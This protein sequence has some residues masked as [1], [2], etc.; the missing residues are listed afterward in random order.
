M[1]KYTHIHETKHSL[2]LF[3]SLFLG[4][5]DFDFL[6]K[7]VFRLK[8]CFHILNTVFRIQVFEICPVLHTRRTR[9]ASRE[10]SRLMITQFN[11]VTEYN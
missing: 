11:G 5:E 2:Y 3:S 7:S 8:T 10:P 9:G 6:Q 4:L 1:D